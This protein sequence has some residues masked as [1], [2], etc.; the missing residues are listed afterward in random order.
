M[1][2]QQLH[3]QLVGHTVVPDERLPAVLGLVLACGHWALVRRVGGHLLGQGVLEVLVA[4]VLVE[5]VAG[6]KHQVAEGAL[7]LKWLA[8]LTY[9]RLFL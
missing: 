5:R 8:N 7:H 2:L 4:Q 3:H 1:L 9:L 6:G